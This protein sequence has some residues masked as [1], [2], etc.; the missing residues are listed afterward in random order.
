MWN[1]SWQPSPP[2]PS[3]PT[4]KIVGFVLEI[5][6]FRFGGNIGRIGIVEDAAQRL[7]ALRELGQRFNPSDEM[8]LQR[9]I[10]RGLAH[11]AVLQLSIEHITGKA[12]IEL[13]AHG[14]HPD[15][16]NGR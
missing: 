6:R 7:Q 9:E 12:A 10:E 15:G 1:A 13:T 2:H 16:H 11:V 14:P 4:S 8:G 5:C 3:P